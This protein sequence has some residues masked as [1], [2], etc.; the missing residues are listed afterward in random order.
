MAR[1]ADTTIQVRLTKEL[2]A[3]FDAVVE[4]KS[5]NKSALLRDL[6]LKWIEENEK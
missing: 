6:L 1:I 2:K 3:R 4:K 5:V